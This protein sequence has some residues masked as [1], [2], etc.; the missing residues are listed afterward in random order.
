MFSVFI[1]RA[2]QNS[3]VMS[4]DLCREYKQ[5]RGKQGL[6][7]EARRRLLESRQLKRRY[8]S[9]GSQFQG[10]GVRQQEAAAALQG[11]STQTNNGAASNG[12]NSVKH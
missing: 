9:L 2:M 11:S 1:L 6:R 3:R 4:S 5:G 12:M 8:V 7:A 10:L